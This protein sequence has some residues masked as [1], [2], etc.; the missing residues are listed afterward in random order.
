[1]NSPIATLHVVTHRRWV[2]DDLA[3]NTVGVPVRHH[4]GFDLPDWEPGDAAWAPM[5]WMARAKVADPRLRLADPGPRFLAALPP[6]LTGRNVEVLTLAQMKERADDHAADH[7]VLVDGPSYFAKPANCKIEAFEARW[8]DLEGHVLTAVAAQVPDAQPFLLTS[9]R[10][11]LVEEHRLFVLEGEVATS[12]P[13]LQHLVQGPHLFQG[14]TTWHEH[15]VSHR[16]GDAEEFG[17]H[18]LDTTTVPRPRAFVLD[19][20]VLR[21]GTWV[22]IETNPVWSSA[23]YGADVDTVVECLAAS[24]EVDEPGSA[25]HEWAPDPWLLERSSRQPLLHP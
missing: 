25:V 19:V 6:E 4:L 14:G 9:T 7:G 13:Y 16:T 10:L 3:T 11:D 1:M 5:E 17:A 18:V 2:A 23:F 12:S 24:V 15:M 22:V 20:G 8:D 21:D